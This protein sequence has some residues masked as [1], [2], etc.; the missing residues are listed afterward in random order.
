VDALA[1]DGI[2]AWQ[3]PRLDLSNGHDHAERTVDANQVD[4]LL[5]PTESRQH[6]KANAMPIKVRSWAGDVAGSTQLERDYGISRST[7]HGWQKQSRV[8]S[9]LAG[10]RKHVFP[11]AQFIDGRPIEGLA[12]VVAATGSPR[13]AWAWLVKPHPSLGARAPLDRLK[14]GEVSA[15]AAIARREFAQT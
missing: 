1:A 14:A 3:A 11:L 2:T 10:A 6:L 4:R 13:T 5:A 8:V 9:L 7:L 12:D 15:V